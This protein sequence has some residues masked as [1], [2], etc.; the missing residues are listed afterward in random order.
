MSIIPPQSIDKDG[1]HRVSQGVQVLKVDRGF[2]DMG[3]LG[4]QVKAGSNRSA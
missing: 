4:W 2:Q 1:E 3:S